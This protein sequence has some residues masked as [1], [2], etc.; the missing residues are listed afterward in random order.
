MDEHDRD[1]PLGYTFVARDAHPTGWP[2]DSRKGWENGAS[3]HPLLYVPT[4][5]PPGPYPMQG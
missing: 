4:H 3:S 2:A 5:I 1:K